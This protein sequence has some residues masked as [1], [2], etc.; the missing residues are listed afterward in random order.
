MAIVN[1]RSAKPDE[2]SIT[3]SWV[4][5]MFDSVPPVEYIIEMKPKDIFR[6]QEIDF[7]FKITDTEVALPA[8]GMKENVEF[9]FRVTA[10]NKAG[11]SKPS[12]PSSAVQIG[13]RLPLVIFYITNKSYHDE[14][15]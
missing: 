4:Q 3:L 5:P 10:K 8:K 13:M 12:E 14:L 7:P 11:K 1:P 9:E 15:F 6:W 2:Q